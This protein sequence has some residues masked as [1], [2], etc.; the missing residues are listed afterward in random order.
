MSSRRHDAVEKSPARKSPEFGNAA[1]IFVDTSK[2]VVPNRIE[3]I[4]TSP[5]QKK[6]R[7]LGNALA[8]P[9]HEA[10]QRNL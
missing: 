8:R 2:N 10:P 5:M 1:S 3:E 4:R 7:G 6:T 9:L